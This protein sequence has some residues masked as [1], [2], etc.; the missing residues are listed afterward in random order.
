MTG[1]VAVLAVLVAWW[2]WPEGAPPPPGGAP[3]AEEP[4]ATAPARLAASVA[5][6]R[7]RPP[8]E[9][10]TAYSDD[11][12]DQPE[13]DE[14]VG[15]EGDEP[16]FFEYS[17]VE[18]YAERPPMSRVPHTVVRGWGARGGG[19]VPGVVGVYVVV[20]PGIS[21]EDLER[22]ALDIS[23]FHHDASALSVRILDSD[24][25]ATYDHHIDGGALAAEHL[26]ATLNRNDQLGTDRLEVRGEPRPTGTNSD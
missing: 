4:R 23:D 21:D 10:P 12:G 6:A 1:V 2:L 11:R 9:A 7:P 13:R 22:L 8:E 20:A 14:P 16:E 19:R 3:V 15:G 18:F 26:V 25:A 17:D 24:R 5:P